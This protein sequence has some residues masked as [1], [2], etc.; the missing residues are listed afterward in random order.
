M[1]AIAVGVD[2]ELNRRVTV[3][4]FDIGWRLAL[5]QE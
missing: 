2:R 5:L 1:G 4:A 3:L